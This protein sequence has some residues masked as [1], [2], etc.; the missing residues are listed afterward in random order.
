MKLV[1]QYNIRKAGTRMVRAG[2][3]LKMVFQ[4]HDG[5]RMVMAD[6]II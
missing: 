6:G 5:F 4:Q 1:Q 3:M 2:Y